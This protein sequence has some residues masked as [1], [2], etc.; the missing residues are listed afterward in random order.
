MKV[1]DRSTFGCVAA[2]CA[3][4]LRTTLARRGDGVVKP[5]AEHHAGQTPP[6]VGGVS[7]S[8]RLVPPPF[9]GDRGD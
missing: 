1:V 4:V 8:G 6:L 9:K 7:P 5:F 3:I 2:D